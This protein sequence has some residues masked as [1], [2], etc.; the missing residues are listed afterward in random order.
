MP[1]ILIVRCF[2]LQGRY[3]D[4]YSTSTFLKSSSFLIC[5]PSSSKFPGASHFSK[6]T[7]AAGQSPS[8]IENQA[9]SR[10]RPCKIMCCR[11]T[12]SKENP[13]LTAARFDASFRLLHFHSTRRMCNSSKKYL[14]RRYVTCKYVSIYEREQ[15]RTRVPGVSVT[16]SLHRQNAEFPSSMQGHILSKKNGASTRIVLPLFRRASLEDTL[17]TL[18]AQSR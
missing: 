7:F 9:V 14:R 17:R 18:H 15:H 3:A 8:S 12:P 11:K 4:P 16:T 5:L 13:S 6:A 10:F 1:E 2:A